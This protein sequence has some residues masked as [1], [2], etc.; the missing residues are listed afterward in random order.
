[1]A[2][3]GGVRAAAITGGEPLE[4]PAFLERLL[5]RLAPLPVL[6]ETAG[7]HPSAL[8]RVID[9]V[10]LVSMD[11]KLPSVS[12]THAAFDVH[13]RFLAIARRRAV[14]VKVVVDDATDPAE[15][16]DAI[17]VV[18]EADPRIPFV[19]Q[20]ET[21][22]DGRLAASFARVEELA[23]AAAAAGLEDV[24]ALPQVH[25]FLGAP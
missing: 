9:A 19:V 14:V 23:V 13:R 24:R 11:L 5:P 1:M 22:P 6:L 16:R 15:W 7:L 21:R 17:R 25:K 20:P 10:W 3:D 8:E 2:E 4:Q 18:A 12:G